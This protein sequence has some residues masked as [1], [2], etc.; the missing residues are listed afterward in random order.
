MVKCFGETPKKTSDVQ[1]RA[2]RLVLL[3]SSA[4]V[5]DMHRMLSWLPVKVK[6]HL[7]LLVYFYK[8]FKYH[9]PCFFFEKLVYVGL[10]YDYKTRQ[11]S[12]DQLFLPCPQTNLMKK[13]VLYRGSV[14]WN[15]VPINIRKSNCTYVFRRKCEDMLINM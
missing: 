11:V 14:A 5:S 1:N 4:N 15:V 10:I 12:R 8:V 9:T 7:R 2:A 6:L 13:T 3:I